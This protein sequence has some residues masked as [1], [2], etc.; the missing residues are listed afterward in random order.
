MLNRIQYSLRNIRRN[1][2]T[3]IITTVG[4]SM[5]LASVLIIYLFITQEKSYN[6]FHE[7]ADR[8]YRI[9]YRIL[10]K[11]GISGFS[12]LVH[13]ELAEKLADEIPQIEHATPFRMGYMAQFDMG[14]RNMKVRLGIAEQA[15]FDIFSFKLLYGNRDELLVNPTNIVLTRSLAE[16]LLENKEDAVEELIGQSVRFTF[17]NNTGFT[18]VGILEDLPKNSSIDFEAIIPYE[19][20]NRF[21]QSNNGFGNSS[22]FYELKEGVDHEQAN[23][24]IAEA[25]KTYYQQDIE[26]AQKNNFLHPSPGC[27]KAF[28]LPIEKT[29]LNNDIF[30]PYEQNGSKAQLKILALVG[31]LILFIAF[32]NYIILTTGQFFKKAGEVSIR[33][34]LGGKNTDILKMF[35]SDNSLLIILSFIAGGILSYYLIPVFNTISQSQIYFNLVNIPSLLIFS[36]ITIFLLITLTSLTPV[37]FFRKVKPTLMATKKLFSGSKA[38]TPKVFIGMQYALTIVLIIATIVITKQTYYLKNKSL[39][40]TD[41][42]IISIDVPYLDQ[43]KSV[44]LRDLLQKEPGVINAALTNRNYFDGYSSCSFEVS[45]SQVMETFIFKADN[46]FIPTL[47]LKLLAGRNFTESDIKDGDRSIIVNEEFVKRVGYTDSPVGKQV[48]GCNGRYDIIGVVNDY[49]FLTS[50]EQIE[51]MVLY[52]DPNYG[53]GYSAVL[54]KYNP[55][56]LSSVLASIKRGWQEINT[57]EELNYIFWDQALQNRYQAE[58]RLSKIILYASLIAIIIL[59]LGLFGLTVLI[60]EQRTQEIG[61]RKVNGARITE[62]MLLLN[63]EYLK[64]VVIAFLIAC[65]I[66]YKVAGKWLENFAYKTELNWWIFALAGLAALLVALLTI[67][68]QSWRAAIKNPV[69]SIRYE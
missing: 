62:V 37:I 48:N 63:K 51:P 41:E 24:L 44:V 15:F 32:A 22:V 61:I 38:V 33:K 64:W 30:A 13:P 47:E 50:R 12:L 42:N 69:E 55:Q 26:R 29:Y 2:L 68:W 49:Q 67:S 3:V 18:I 7:K 39:G 28:M 35:L 46:Y 9:N 40:F 1:K 36:V 31:I 59:T 58:E 21:W 54:L 14:D 11:N 25:V 23:Y 65:P 57:K 27:F 8:I 4:L 6:N 45:G 10:M 53:N 60:S 16:K 19:Y 56:N 34:S 17:I 43:A 52:A 20:Q 5:A 66:A